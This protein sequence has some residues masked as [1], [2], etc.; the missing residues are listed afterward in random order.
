MEGIP[1]RPSRRQVLGM[2]AGAVF[3]SQKAEAAPV[4]EKQPEGGPIIPKPLPPE[5]DTS[6]DS[7]ELTEFLEWFTSEYGTVADMLYGGMPPEAATL[8]RQSIRFYAVDSSEGNS[9]PV[10]V[11]EDA[12]VCARQVWQLMRQDKFISVPEVLH[13]QVKDM[14]KLY[15]RAAKE[16]REGIKREVPEE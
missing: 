4:P 11:F 13:A 16:W 3:G 8:L 14:C 5:L 10:G 1:P 6:D 9:N 2:L 12:D 15:A 7:Q